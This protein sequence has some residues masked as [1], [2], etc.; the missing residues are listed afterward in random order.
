MK[1]IIEKQINQK[2]SNYSKEDLFSEESN[3]EDLI[4]NWKLIE[5]IDKWNYGN[6][7][8]LV[9]TILNLVKNKKEL[10]ISYY[11]WNHN[12]EFL[13]SFIKDRKFNYDN[14]KVNLDFEN[15]FLSNDLIKI[16]KFFTEADLYTKQLV[17]CFLL[18]KISLSDQKLINLGI[19]T[20]IIE[21]E[22]FFNYLLNN[23]FN[24][25]GKNEQ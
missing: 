2:I 16:K 4:L 15:L 11:R 22:I 25:K 18:T 1:V 19:N 20:N 12:L 8:K 10:R 3:K 6:F 7:K 13:L 14:F 9:F 17:N 21:N 23:Y 24:L 5:N